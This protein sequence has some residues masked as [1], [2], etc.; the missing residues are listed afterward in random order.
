MTARH[1]GVLPISLGLLLVLSASGAEIPTER[2]SRPGEYR[3]YS[4]ARFDG[5]RMES[6]YV[7]VRDGTRIALDIIRPMRGGQLATGKLPVVWMNTPYNRRLT[8]NGLTAELYPG[9]AMGLVRHGYVVAVADMRGNYASFG[10]AVATNRNQ[11]MPWA[12]WDAYDITEWLAVQ[13]WSDGNIGM[14]GC[15]ATGHTQWQAAASRPPHLKAIFPLSA[16]SEYYD[17][18]GITAGDAGRT[19]PAWPGAIPELDAR[20]VP[21]DDDRDGALLAAAKDEHRWNLQPGPMPFRDSIAPWLKPIGLDDFRYHLEVNTFAHFDDINASGVAAY[22][23]A[24]FGEDQRAKL[25]V[26]IKQRNLRIP[27]KTILGPGNHCN[28][29]SDYRSSDPLLDFNITTEELRWFDY[30]L[31]GVRNGIMDEPPIYYYTYNTQPQDAWRFAWQWPLPTEQAVDYF[32]ADDGAARILSTTAPRVTDASDAYLVDYGVTPANRNQRAMVYT[33]PP[34]ETDTTV[35]GHPVLRL[36]IS[37]TAPDGDFLAFL[38]DVSPDGTVTPLPGTD[39]GQLRASHRALHAAPYDNLGLP[40]HRSYATDVRPL[41][42]GEP[43]ELVFDLAPV[44]H[45]FKAGHRIRLIISCVAI[46]RPGSPAQTPV[47][48][49]VPTVRFHRDAIRS[50]RLTLPVNAPIRARLQVEVRGELAIATVSFP[51]S[52]DPRY[53]ADLRPG[54]IRC[55][56]RPARSSRPAGHVLSVECQGGSPTAGSAMRVEGQFGGRF[57]YGPLMSFSADGAVAR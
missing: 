53:V 16:P 27:N 3:G 26:M 39:D 22:Q 15:S 44:S 2:V 25:G 20:A 31:K 36:W 12:Y 23:S 24:N 41:I 38:A 10:K 49:P 48:D 43:A 4:S 30:W 34:L 35:T 19:A 37:S 47:L 54:S 40:Y 32:L 50:S 7:P 57:H 5:Y 21:V 9:A 33:T 55:N 51:S 6:R 56:G 52:L 42:P 13:P 18:G 29:R 11:W 17:W 46:P 45:V 1:G 14:W 8:D 28:W